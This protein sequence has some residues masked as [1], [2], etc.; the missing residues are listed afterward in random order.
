MINE[1]EGAHFMALDEFNEYLNL[2]LNR[3]NVG[4]FDLK[5]QELLVIPVVRY[6]N[7]MCQI[8]LSLSDSD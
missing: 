1:E 7:T 8:L 5:Q 6:C 3:M 2:F 4:S